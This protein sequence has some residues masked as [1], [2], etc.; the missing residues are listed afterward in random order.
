MRKNFL[1][2]LEMYSEEKIQEIENIISYSIDTVES[3]ILH[4]AVSMQ[5]LVAA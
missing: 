3:A 5:E 4:A 2:G 1:E